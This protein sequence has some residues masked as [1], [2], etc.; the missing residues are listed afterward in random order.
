MDGPRVEYESCLKKSKVMHKLSNIVQKYTQHNYNTTQPLSI[1]KH[2]LLDP[3]CPEDRR[4]KHG[5]LSIDSAGILASLFVQDVW[6]SRLTA[7]NDR[8]KPISIE[9]PLD[10][11]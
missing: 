2:A 5:A 7:D 11:R 8:Y 4:D 1:K 6:L 3:R 10:S 9:I